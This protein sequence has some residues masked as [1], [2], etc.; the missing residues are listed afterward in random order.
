MIGLYIRFLYLTAIAPTHAVRG[1]ILTLVT[2]LFG[3]TTEFYILWLMVSRLGGI[4]QWTPHQILFSAGLNLLSYSAAAFFFLH[5]C[6]R[7]PQRLENGEFDMFLSRPIPCLLHMI[8]RDCSVTYCANILFGVAVIVLA[9]YH[10]P[11]GAGAL[12][13]VG[14][15]SLLSG[16]LIFAALFLIAAALNLWISDSSA[17]RELLV[18]D[19]GYASRFPLMIFPTPFRMALEFVVPLSFVSYVPCR[20]IVEPS[21]SNLILTAVGS[22]G[23]GLFAITIA[24]CFWRAS[25]ANYQKAG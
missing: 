3:F 10:I 21:A 15:V 25:I 22:L 17:I 16:T 6:L 9:G 2:K 12:C 19:L 20:A 11:T 14:V 13:Y 1:L 24:C 4:D 8:C 23:V 5:P 18:G 7:L